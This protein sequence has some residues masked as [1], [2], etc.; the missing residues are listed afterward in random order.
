MS[1]YE[2]TLEI[3]FGR[4]RSQILYA[5]VRLGVFDCVRSVPK[6]SIDIA[7]ELNLDD[8]LAYRLLRALGSLGL[9]IEDGNHDFS[10]TIQGEFLQKDHP[11]TLRGIALLEEGREHYALWKHLPAMI[12]E[13]KQNAF[14]REYGQKLFEYTDNN[15]PYRDV[16]NQAMSSYSSIQTALISEALDGYDFSNIHHLC[17][18]GGG[19]GHLLSSLLLKYPHL[20]G[21]ILELDSALKNK[22]FLWARKMGVEDRCTY[23]IGDMFDE[24]PTADAYILKMILHD[25]SDDECVN[26]L[27][28]IYQASSNRGTLFIAEHL[29]PGPEKPHFSKLF[30]IHMMCVASGRERTIEEYAELLKRAG[31]K[32]ANTFQSSSGLMGVIQ[33]NK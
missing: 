23:V 19:Q 27:S 1:N 30:D 15:P 2:K 6:S 14:L 16:F 7:K 11:Q 10:I 25:W 3:I 26:I 17:D 18:V 4:W 29:V 12:R 20:K 32:H 31:W 8:T 33:G 21:S 28:N 5:G 9:L 22:E 24:V 13:G